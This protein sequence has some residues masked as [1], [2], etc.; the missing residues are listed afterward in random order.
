MSAGMVTSDEPGLYRAGKYGIRIENLLANVFAGQS[1]FGRFLGFETLTLCPIDL[2]P[3]ITER[4]LEDEK[5]WI[6]NYHAAVFTL[7]SKRLDDKDT[8]EWLRTHTLEIS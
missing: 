8:L 4:L 7:L 1:E 2:K 5:A 3:V 6:N